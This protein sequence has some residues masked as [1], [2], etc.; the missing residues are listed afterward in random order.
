MSDSSPDDPLTTD[1]LGGSSGYSRTSRR[2]APSGGASGG[3]QSGIYA[4]LVLGLVGVIVLGWLA[5]SAQTELVA[6]QSEDQD[7]RAR[8]GEIEARLQISD[9]TRSR[10][11]TEIEGQVDFWEDEIRKLWA[12]TNER[13]KNW[14]TENQAAVK[15]AQG[16]IANI[17]KQLDSLNA[18]VARVEK[19][20]QNQQDIMNQLDRLSRLVTEVGRTARDSA[21]KSNT[22]SITLA[23]MESELSK[24]LKENEEFQKSVDAFRRQTNTRIESLRAEV[25]GTPPLPRSSI[26]AI[27]E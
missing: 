2:S 11:D 15:T 5:F 25:Q 14:I 17:N 24:L 6:L 27:E 26:G 3:R 20:F 16:R 7:A 19:G 1:G 9:E 4:L 18:A 10:A 13:N 12:V 8:L 22:A 21:D 23:R